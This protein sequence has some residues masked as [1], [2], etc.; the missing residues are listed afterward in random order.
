MLGT[1]LLTSHILGE[2]KGTFSPVALYWVIDLFV[3]L[4]GRE[5]IEGK[6]HWH[7][8]EAFLSVLQ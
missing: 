6:M 8:R 3:G 7:D 5:N 4:V 1:A 2:S